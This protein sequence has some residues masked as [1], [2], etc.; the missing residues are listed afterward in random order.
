MAYTIPLQEA[1]PLVDQEFDRLD[2][3]LGLGE[4]EAVRSGCAAVLTS[5]TSTPAQHAWANTL[6]G[7][8][9][10]ASNGFERA[11]QLCSKGIAAPEPT[12]SRA[13]TGMGQSL[14]ALGRSAEALSILEPLVIEAPNCHHVW[15]A[16]AQCYLVLKQPDDA[17]KCFVRSSTL[18][19]D[20]IPVIWAMTQIGSS[21]E[22]FSDLAKALKNHLDVQPFNLDAWGSLGLCLLLLGEEHEALRHMERVIEFVP[23]APISP[24]LLLKLRET[25][26]VY[27]SK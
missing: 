5:P 1:E 7:L 11:Y 25:M 22:R 26:A 10:L 20:C 4:H 3:H 17:W 14:L 9:E 13:L 8:V 15:F 23:F 21:P 12:H 6:L 16:L 2:W 18:A 19:P 24:E 27:A